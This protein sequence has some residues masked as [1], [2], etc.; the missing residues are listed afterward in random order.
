MAENQK[1]GEKMRGSTDSHQ[2][3]V[4]LLENKV[5]SLQQDLEV[6]RSELEMVQAEYDGYKVCM[7]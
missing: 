5:T 2:R 1:L 7:T 6:T 3:S 4:R